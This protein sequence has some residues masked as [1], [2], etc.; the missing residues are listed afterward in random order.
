MGAVMTVL[1]KDP[2]WPNVIQNLRDKNFMQK[3]R[4]QENQ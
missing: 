1:E 4:D 3:L 2:S